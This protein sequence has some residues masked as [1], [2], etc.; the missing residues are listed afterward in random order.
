MVQPLISA[1]VQEDDWVHIDSALDT[2]TA[3][4]PRPPTIIPVLQGDTSTSDVELP[5]STAPP[6]MSTVSDATFDNTQPHSDKVFDQRVAMK[7]S[8]LSSSMDNSTDLQIQVFPHSTTDDSMFAC[9]GDSSISDVDDSAMQYEQQLQDVAVVTE[10]TVFSDRSSSSQISL[11]VNINDDVKSQE[12][13]VETQVTTDDPTL[14]TE[15]KVEIL[16]DG[17]IVTRK[18]TKTIRKRMVAKRVLTKSE[19]GDVSFGPDNNNDL[20]VQKF[21]SLG[22]LEQSEEYTR[23]DSDNSPSDESATAQFLA[24]TKDGVRDIEQTYTDDLPSD[25]DVERK[26]TVVQSQTT[27]IEGEDA[28]ADSDIAGMASAPSKQ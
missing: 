27:C 26:I 23:P 21:L 18:I 3:N 14:H 4:E 11:S 15:T 13:V 10:D 8:G 12:T 19:D 2:V 25:I 7:D 22:G 24:M 16:P 17:T 5:F 20:K 9:S 28:I 1:E 6:I